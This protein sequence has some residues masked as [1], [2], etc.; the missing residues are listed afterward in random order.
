[1]KGRGYT[2]FISAFTCEQ[3]RSSVVAKTEENPFIIIHSESAAQ[4]GEKIN[5]K[6]DVEAVSREFWVVNALLNPRSSTLPYGCVKK[7]VLHRKAISF[8]AS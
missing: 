7:R 6:I 8:V 3:K 1:M 4:K 2:W 5:N